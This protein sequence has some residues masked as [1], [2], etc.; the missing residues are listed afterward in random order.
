MGHWSDTVKIPLFILAFM[1]PIFMISLYSCL[2][3][4]FTLVNASNRKRYEDEIKDL[5][6]EIQELTKEADKL[7]QQAK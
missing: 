3:I 4:I 7:R 2:A 6:L 5:E 1:V